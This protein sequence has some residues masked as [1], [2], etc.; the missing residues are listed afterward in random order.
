MRS[1]GRIQVSRIRSALDRKTQGQV[2][3]VT[4]DKASD[5]TDRI[6]RLV[7]SIKGDCPVSGDGVNLPWQWAVAVSLA[8]GQPMVVQRGCLP[9]GAVR[10]FVEPAVCALLS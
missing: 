6:E 5:G 1:L 8:A 4:V 2:L 7:F 10:I 3:D 9:G